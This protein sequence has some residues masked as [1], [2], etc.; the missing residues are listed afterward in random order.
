MTSAL[1][2]TRGVGALTFGIIE[3]GGRVWSDAV[4]LVPQAAGMVLRALLI[5]NERRAERPIVLLRLFADRRRSGAYPARATY[6]AAMIGF[7]FFTPQLMQGVFG[8][9]VWALLT[10][11]A[12]GFTFEVFSTYGVPISDWAAVFSALTEDDHAPPA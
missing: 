8:T 2:A 3:S 4:V 11:E 7:V 1:V 12:R 10:S 6:L 5:G 9:L